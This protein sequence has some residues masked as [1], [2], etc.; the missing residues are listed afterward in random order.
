MENNV[1][2]QSVLT[3]DE[4]SVLYKFENEKVCRIITSGKG[5]RYDSRV[6]EF[7]KTNNSI[8]IEGE[9]YFVNNNSP[10]SIRFDRN[11]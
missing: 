3:R 7:V 9:K 2:N 5:Y 6:G 1:L 10:I 11:T 8:Q 4:H